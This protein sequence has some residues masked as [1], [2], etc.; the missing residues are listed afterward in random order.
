MDPLLRNPKYFNLSIYSQIEIRQGCLFPARHIFGGGG[1]PEMA[2]DTFCGMFIP[3]QTHFAGRAR[4][5]LG[6]K[7]SR[8][9]ATLGPAPQ[10]FHPQHI[11]PNYRGFA[12]LRMIKL[13]PPTIFPKAKFRHRNQLAWT[14]QT[15]GGCWFGQIHHWLVSTLPVIDSTVFFC[16]TF[17]G[18]KWKFFERLQVFIAGEAGILR[19]GSIV[20]SQGLYGTSYPTSN[21]H[22][23]EFWGPPSTPSVRSTPQ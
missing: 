22:H 7:P 19:A 10:R 3:R 1:W 12:S 16:L 9:A 4:D 6:Q 20:F 2:S 17:R 11:L 23:L 15:T 8:A 14:E 13:S 21:D 5:G 18:E